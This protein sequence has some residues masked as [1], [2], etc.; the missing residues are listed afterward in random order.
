MFT[1][2]H[3]SSSSISEDCVP[4]IRTSRRRRGAGQLRKIKL[5]KLDPAAVEKQGEEIKTHYTKLFGV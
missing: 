2:E 3:S 5:M 4:C 1:A